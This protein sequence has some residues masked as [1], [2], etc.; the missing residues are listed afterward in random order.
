MYS[1]KGLIGHIFMQCCRIFSLKNKV[2]FSSFEGGGYSDNPRA[3]FEE[4]VKEKLEYEY[5]WLMCDEKVIIE[6]AKVVKI[7]SFKALFHLATSKIWIDNCRKREWILKRKNQYYIQTWHGGFSLKKIEGDVIDKM[8]AEYIRNA[9]HDSKIADLFI[10]GCRWSTENYRSAFWY[11]GPILELGQPRSVI[12]YKNQ[13]NIKQKVYDF[14]KLKSDCKLLLYAPTFRA[15]HEINNYNIDYD[16]LIKKLKEK[17]RGEWKIIVRL[18]PSVANK[19]NNIVYSD[20]LL[21]GSCYS[22]INELIIS[23]DILISDYSSCMFDAMEAKKKVIIY[24]SD[25]EEYNNDRGTYLEL[26]NL[27]FLITQNNEELLN[28]IE[29]FREEVYEE[30]THVFMEKIGFFNSE[31]STEKIV[32]YIIDN[33][34]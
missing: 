17:W 15:N 30:K 8:P 19:Q 4:M 21:N 1:F 32:K 6:N 18:H 13:D 11:N 22:D 26:N 10:S 31:E 5:I 27:P 28:S 20:F 34:H 29:N 3:I 9:K 33:A 2:V 24:A 23:C 16:K 7:N 25:L 12:F 14:Y